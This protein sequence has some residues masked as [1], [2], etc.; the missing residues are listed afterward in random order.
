EFGDE[1]RGALRLVA[2]RD[3]RDGSVVINQDVS[4]YATLLEV[5]QTVEHGIAPGRHVWVQIVRGRVR[6][7]ELELSE[8]D[9]AALTGEDRVALEALEAAEL[10]LFD[11]A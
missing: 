2:S 11:L 9:G 5:G 8:G 4:M 6:L 3:G 1:R 7:G 10:L